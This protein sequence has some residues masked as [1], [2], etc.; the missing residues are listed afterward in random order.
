[1][2]CQ[3]SQRSRRGRQRRSNEG[4]TLVQMSVQSRRG[5]PRQS[6]FQKLQI[7]F[8]TLSSFQSVECGT[9]LWIAHVDISSLTEEEAPVVPVTCRNFGRL[10]KRRS[11]RL[12]LQLQYCDGLLKIQSS[13]ASSV[14]TLNLDTVLFQASLVLTVKALILTRLRFWV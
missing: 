8:Q 1:M 9:F 5:E 4:T 14:P 13:I 10:L 2:L 12:C 6:R 3:W 7:V 11:C